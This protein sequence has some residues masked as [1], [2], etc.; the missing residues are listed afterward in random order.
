[1]K[2]KGESWLWS[3]LCPYERLGSGGQVAYSGAW[4]VGR[5]GGKAGGYS[6]GDC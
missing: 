5:W 6:C 1:M 2:D 3:G 4:P